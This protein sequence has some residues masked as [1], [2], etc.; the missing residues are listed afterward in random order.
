MNHQPFWPMEGF[1]RVSS[2]KGDDF[3]NASDV[4]LSQPWED[5]VVMDVDM[6]MMIWMMIWMMKMMKMM[7]MMMMM[8]MMMIPICSMYGIFTYFWTEF[9]VTVCRYSIHG[10]YG[11]MMTM[12]QPALWQLRNMPHFFVRYG[13]GFSF[14]YTKA[15]W[16]LVPFPDTEWSE[17]GESWSF[18]FLGNPQIP[19]Y[20]WPKKVFLEFSTIQ[21]L[22]T[23][24]PRH[25][26]PLAEVRYDWTPKGTKPQGSM[27][28]C[29]QATYPQV[30]FFYVGNAKNPG[31]ICCMQ[32][33][34]NGPQLYF[35]D[36]FISQ[37]KAS[38]N[39]KQP[40]WLMES[41]RPFCYFSWLM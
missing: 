16:Q 31:F 26:G 24:N 25:P 38:R 19:G 40:G 37:L 6:W 4:D 33:M 1:L 22:S 8:M 5:D 20:F 15:A 23:Y 18:E 17:D 2:S 41:I 14:V 39:L 35:R 12:R 11:M 13:Y 7:K 36:Y 28:G 21:K 10:A 29:R 9:M 3:S 30:D 32:G 27:A 34:T